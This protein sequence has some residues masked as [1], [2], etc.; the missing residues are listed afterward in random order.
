MPVKREISPDY[1]NSEPEEEVKTPSLSTTESSPQTPKKKNQSKVNESKTPSPK[2]IK[3]SP[4]K[5][6]SL[7]SN[8]DNEN[9]SAKAKYAMMIID[10]GIET[11]K[12][13]EVEAATG[14]KANQQKDM[15]R[16]DGKGALYKALM[17][18]CKTL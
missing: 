15:T 11:L 14:L 7:T 2:K 6:V 13:D 5:Q 9:L 18:S 12:K 1:Y 3:S 8:D 10:K 4:K 17:G 16:K